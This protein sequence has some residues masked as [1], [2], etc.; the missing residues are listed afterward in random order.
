MARYSLKEA[1]KLMAQIGRG[2]VIEPQDHKDRAKIN[3]GLRIVRPPPKGEALFEYYLRTIAPDIHAL[4]PEHDVPVFEGDDRRCDWSFLPELPLVIEIHGDV[5]QIIRHGRETFA[6]VAKLESD[7]CKANEYHLRGIMCLTFTTSQL[8]RDPYPAFETIRRGI[9]IC[10]L[11]K[12]V[13]MVHT[14]EGE[15]E[16]E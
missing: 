13:P 10:K 6:N 8:E 1:R 3:Q 4:G 7:A 12:I 16:T 15:N 5:H 11:R 14:S 2:Q 9:E